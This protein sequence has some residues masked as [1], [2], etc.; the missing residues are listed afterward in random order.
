M[1]KRPI[2]A[3]VKLG[4][5][6]KFVSIG[7]ESVAMERVVDTWCGGRG[8]LRRERASGVLEKESSGTGGDV[9]ERPVGAGTMVMHW[10]GTEECRFWLRPELLVGVYCFGK[11]EQLRASQVV[12]SLGAASAFAEETGAVAKRITESVGR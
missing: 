11:E 4:I 9:L 6:S 7:V 8:G 5:L 10:Q 3:L 1:P 12:P 2:T